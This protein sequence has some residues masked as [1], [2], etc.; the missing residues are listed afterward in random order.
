MQDSGKPTTLETLRLLDQHLKQ[1]KFPALP[2]P[3]VLPHEK[4]TLELVQWGI[5]AYCYPWLRHLSTLI[6][7]MLTLNDVGNMASLRIIG[8]SSYEICA[9][10]Y[11]VKKHVKQHLDAKNLEAAWEFLVPASTGSRYITQ[12]HPE[13]EDLFPTGAH[14]SKVVNCFKEIMPTGTGIKNDDDYSYL[15]EFCHPN[16]MAFAQHYEITEKGVE[17]RYTQKSEIGAFG[18]ITASAMQGLLTI[19]EL[20]ELGNETEVRRDIV[21]M[22]SELATLAMKDNQN[23]TS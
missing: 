1:I 23:R 5:K 17:I 15:S 20:L 11:Y 18:G 4:P 21:K 6:S 3:R 2:R 7:G 10:V 13:T 22:L 14:I 16:M 9:H 19:I 8:R 12:L